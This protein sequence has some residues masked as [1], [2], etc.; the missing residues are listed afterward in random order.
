MGYTP[1]RGIGKNQK[2]ALSEPLVLKPRPRGL[3][4]GA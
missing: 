3:G 4:L 1:T 2:N